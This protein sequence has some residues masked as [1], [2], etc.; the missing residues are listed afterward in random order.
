MCR[1]ALKTNIPGYE[2]PHHH[3]HFCHGHTVPSAPGGRQ[4][5]SLDEAL[6]AQ[7]HA[8]SQVPSPYQ[9]ERHPPFQPVPPLLPHT[10]V[11]EPCP[12]SSRLHT[13]MQR[14]ELPQWALSLGGLRLLPLYPSSNGRALD[15]L[16][17]C[18]IQRFLSCQEV[19]PGAAGSAPP[20]SGL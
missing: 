4:P 6:H 13:Q 12:A 3:G 5:L 19:S 14:L 9:L 17:P 11:C 7:P 15:A 10:R 8:R 1:V 20:L 18:V 16:S 2:Q